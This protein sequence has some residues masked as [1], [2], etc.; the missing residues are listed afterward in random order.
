MAATDSNVPRLCL[1]HLLL[2]LL[3]GSILFAYAAR[4]ETVIFIDSPTHGFLRSSSYAQSDSMSIPDVAAAV[5]MLLGFAPS[6]MISATSASTLNNILCPNPFNRP[7]AVFLLEV[8]A[9]AEHL[10]LSRFSASL[11]R[12]INSVG[13]S[14]SIQLPGGDESF[15]IPLDEPLSNDGWTDKNI[16]DFALW[17]GGSYVSDAVKPLNG[18]LNFPLDDGAE[19]KLQMS[20]V[21]D[22]EFTINLLTLVH[23]VQ[24][25]KK[26]HLE[27]TN[28]GHRPAELLMGSF[29]CFKGLKEKHNTGVTQQRLELLVATSFKIFDMLLDAYSGQIVGVVLLNKEASAESVSLFDVTFSAQSSRWLAEKE[30][31]SDSISIA[32]VLLVRQTLAWITGILLLI[33]TLLGVYFLMNMPLTRDTLLYS[34]VK[35]D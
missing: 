18:E 21:A 4:S 3:T 34:N 27:A 32:R 7:R 2:L 14:A 6:Q 9:V 5:S 8:P 30:D 28:N 15:F 25:A 19:V 35:L 17:I 23:N 16:A 1:S 26:L 20:Q 12:K 29:D 10:F 33:A 13:N 11:N 24:K 31:A 22:K